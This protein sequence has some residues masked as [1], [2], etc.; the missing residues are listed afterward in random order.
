MGRMSGDN[1]IKPASGPTAMGITDIRESTGA[2]PGFLKA[3]GGGG[4]LGLQAK[5]GV[6]E[7]VQL[8]AQC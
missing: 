4:I 1:M 5:G 3:G 8:W 2:D 6:Q 7:G